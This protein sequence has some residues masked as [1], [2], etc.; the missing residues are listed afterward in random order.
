MARHTRDSVRAHLQT[1]GLTL[2]RVEGDWRVTFKAPP[3]A[4]ARQLERLEELAAYCPDLE[5]ALLTGCA[6]HA[7][8]CRF[9]QH[10]VDL[11]AALH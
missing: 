7:H 4:T 3:G 6:M 8:R 9:P 11:G 10:Y 5:E 1:L 2:K